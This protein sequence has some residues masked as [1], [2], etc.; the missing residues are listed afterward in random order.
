MGE[1]PSHPALLDYLA[2]Q[3]IDDDWSTKS[4]I[5]RIVLSRVYRQSSTADASS[6]ADD[7]E[8]QLF[9]RANRR[10]LDAEAI[11]D[12]MLHVSGQLDDTAGGLTITKLAQ[13]DIDYKFGDIRCRSVYVPRFR[14]SPLGLFQVFDA[15][16]P[17]L[18]TG[19]RTTTNLPT[20]SLYLM[21]SPYVS[22]QAEHAARRL[23]AIDDLDET[24]RIQLAFRWALGRRATDG[25]VQL[26]S[27]FLGDANDGQAKAWQGVFQMLFAC[28]DF[29]YLN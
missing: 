7:P 29:R 23:L 14:N 3:F 20:Q 21:N 17:N 4:L 8:N 26:A 9:C 2:Q 19:R 22:R 1:R 10:R 24:D 12:G 16:N 5:R 18:S 15:A 27:N 25:E 28:L 11:R 6:T 13:Y